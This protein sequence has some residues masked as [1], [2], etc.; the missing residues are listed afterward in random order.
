MGA[1]VLV[2]ARSA[3][4]PSDDSGGVVALHPSTGLMNEHRAVF[5]V[6]DRLVESSRRPRCERD[7]CSCAAFADDLEGV[8][9]ALQPRIADVSS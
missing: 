3:G 4:E 8:V 2:D 6:A 9:A 1:D 7:Q 5:S